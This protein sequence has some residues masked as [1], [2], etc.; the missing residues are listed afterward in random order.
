MRSADLGS[1]GLQYAV[2][3]QRI[4]E[5]EMTPS[6]LDHATFTI[7]RRYDATPALI[8]QAYA[9]PAIKRRWFAGGEGFTVDD[10]SLDFRIG[11]RES[12]AFRFGDGSP[13]TFEA[14]ILD[15]VPDRR[16]IIA[17]AMTIGG[18]RISASQATVEITPDGEGAQV[19]YTEQ[20]AFLDG[21]DQAAQRE[22]GSKELQE[23][24]ARELDRQLEQA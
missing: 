24:L 4:N 16:I 8:F 15:I 12:C 11:G 18:Q 13:M 10:D 20:A 14:T 3:F 2:S 21:L 6:S 5:A 1:N 17:Y 19:A 22:A 7:A 9:D 23:A